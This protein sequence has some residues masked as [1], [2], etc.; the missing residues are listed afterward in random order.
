[1]Q[2]EATVLADDGDTPSLDS[3]STAAPQGLPAPAHAPV[4]RRTLISDYKEIGTDLWHARDLLHQLTLRDIR[5]R[6]K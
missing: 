6:Y 4:P 5:I 3:S 2:A 1:M